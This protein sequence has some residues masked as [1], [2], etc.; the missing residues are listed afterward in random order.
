[1]GSKIK[2]LGIECI[3]LFI[4][5]SFAFFG[6]KGLQKNNSIKTVVIDAGHGGK[7]PGTVVGRAKEKNIVLDIALKLGNLI[8]QNQN[9]KVVYIRDGDYFVPLMDRA[10]IANKANA[11][12]FISIHA[13]YCGSPDIYGTET[14]VLGLHR[15]ED[16]LNV[17][18]KENSVILLEEDYSTRYE[19]FN[20]NL[21]ESYIMF[22]L[23][24]DAYL[25]QSLRFATI[26]QS[27]FKEVAQRHDRDVRQAGFLVL[28][29]TAMPSV[30]IETGYLSNR[31]ENSF[32]QTDNGRS[33]LAHSIYSSL[34]N[35]LNKLDTKEIVQDNQSKGT[36]QESNRIQIQKPSPGKKQDEFEP[37][38]VEKNIKAE[39]SQGKEQQKDKNKKTDDKTEAGINIAKHGVT[40]AIQ[41][42]VY[43]RKVISNSK[44][45]KGISPIKEM[46]IDGKY[47]YF[48]F[49]SDSFQT[50]KSNYEE[51]SKKFPDAFIVEIQNNNTR[52]VWIK[53][54]KK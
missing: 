17:A 50:T 33:E 19:G 45:F 44:S 34:L 6:A 2:T 5:F 16:N 24:Q 27:N 3:C 35:Y 25:E 23:V 43:S 28:R 20:P 13:N 1:M 36:T 49:E 37:S 26:L 46:I 48:C 11:D 12:L 51:I 9:I 42:G 39:P 54:G 41:I 53:E 38:P 40:Y 30:L 52:R 8:K 7:D 15:T 10:Q 18:K 14:Y 47:K 21:S 31:K 29:E 32:L 22:E 4:I